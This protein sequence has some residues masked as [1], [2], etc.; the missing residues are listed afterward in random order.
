MVHTISTLP[1]PLI[2]APRCSPNYV[3]HLELKNSSAILFSCLPTAMFG[4]WGLVMYLSN[5]ILHAPKLYI[6]RLQK[7]KEKNLV[8]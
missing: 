8:V 4:M 7:K 3:G 2:R 1:Y 6:L 5:G